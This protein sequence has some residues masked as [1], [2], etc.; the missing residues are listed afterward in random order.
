MKDRDAQL[1]AKLVQKKMEVKQ[2]RADVQRLKMQLDGIRQRR[3][4]QQEMKHREFYLHT[5]IEELAK[6]WPRRTLNNQTDDSPVRMYFEN[7]APRIRQEIAKSKWRC[8]L[9][10]EDDK[11][12]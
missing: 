8:P 4:E 2:G 12:K 1:I 3:A 6:L 11:K 7:E 5:I 10:D 9:L